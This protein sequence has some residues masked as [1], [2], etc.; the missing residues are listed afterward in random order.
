M[1]RTKE[2]GLAS[3]KHPN[4]YYDKGFGCEAVK[5]LPGEFYA[6]DRDVALVTVL[7]SCVA[8]CIRDRNTGIGGMNHFMLPREHDAP[9][10]VSRSLRFGAYAMEI[11]INK[12]LGMGAQR[13]ALEAK[14][15]GGGSVMR[16]LTSLNIGE[17]NAAFVTE[18][19]RNERIAVTAD[20]L[21]GTEPRKVYFFPA[22]GRVMVRTIK[23]LHNRT[24]LE[25]ESIYK[26]R[27][28]SLP[29]G[30]EIEIFK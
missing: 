14:V 17:S 23:Q 21:M 5:V 9:S 1:I 28:N 30:G 25:R 27:L 29:A 12:L 13:G 26:L 22:S 11:L 18:Y 8:A 7:G 4:S 10:P 20:D 3:G 6:T 24:I 15:F 16:G 19:L 2:H